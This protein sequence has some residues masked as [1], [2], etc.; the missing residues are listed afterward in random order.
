MQAL[1]RVQEI[2]Q[3]TATFDATYELN[4]RQEVIRGEG[5][6]SVHFAV[7]AYRNN[8]EL[9]VVLQKI[10]LLTAMLLFSMSFYYGLARVAI[11]A[12]SL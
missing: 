5:G 9:P 11:W 8:L 12:V 6:Y 4:P 3:R 7:Y 2:Q 1:V 10:G